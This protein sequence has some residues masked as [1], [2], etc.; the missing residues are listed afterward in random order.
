MAFVKF[1]NVSLEF[2]IYN[3][4]TMSLRHNLLRITTGGRI[5]QDSSKHIVIRSLDD[6]SFQFDDGDSIGLIGH[7]G[8]G[9]STL[10][11]TI[12]GIYHP[13]GGQVIREG[14]VSTV[15]ELGAGIDYELSGYENILRMAMLQGVGYKE[16]L[17]I[18]D[19]VADFTGLGD[20]LN[21]PVRT[22]SS[23]M[24]MRLM[25]GVATS[26]KPEILLVDEM[27]STGDAEFQEKAIQRMKHI[28]KSSKLF[29]L[30]SHDINMIKLMCNRIFKL[31]HGKVEE[32]KVEL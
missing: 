10:L 26:I 20:F 11:R 18:L 14:K 15:F 12:A 3:A 1:E 30:A 19:N 5:S 4:K 6:V 27:I 13:T 2:P 8:A 25:F 16:A 21:L 29:V 7:N 24:T 23:G 32:I 31:E 28:S 9:K 22:Y 17:S